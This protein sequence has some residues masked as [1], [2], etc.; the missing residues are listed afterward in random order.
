MNDYLPQ[1]RVEQIRLA[2]SQ[3]PILTVTNIVGSAILMS[4]MRGLVPDTVLYAWIIVVFLTVV[5]ATS[6]LL[7]FYQSDTLTEQNA[8]KWNRRIV[9]L[10]FFRA[11]AWGSSGF[12]FFVPNDHLQQLMIFS[13][14]LVGSFF[15]TMQ[16]AAHKPGFYAASVFIVLPVTARHFLEIGPFHTTL[17]WLG[18]L[19]LVTLIYFYRKIH[20][21]LQDSLLLRFEKSD[22]AQK[23]EAQKT[24]LEYQKQQAEQANLAKSQFLA[25]ASHDLRQPLHAQGLFVGELQERVRDR[26]CQQ[27]LA[28]LK[29]SM[30]AMHGLFNSLLDISR[31]EAQV[32]EP[33][34][35][36]FSIK[37]LLRELHLDF[38][39][40][41]RD[42][43][44]ILRVVDS[45]AVIRSDP[46]LLQRILRNL[47]SNAVRYTF[48]GKIL[49]GCR[50]R[51]EYLQIQ[52]WDTGIGIPV[53]D[54]KLIFQEFRQLHNPER[55][56]QKGL[57]LGLAIV[58]RLAKLL[59]YTVE[60]TS[61]VNKGSV[62]SVTVPYVN[63][64]KAR[65]AAPSMTIDK[66]SGLDG[67]VIVV[68]DDEQDILI[69]MRR[70][71]TQWGC[72]VLTAESAAE[73]IAQIHA[74]AT[75]PTAIIADYRLHD[76]ETGI[77]AIKTIT[78]RFNKKIPGV[79]ITGDTAPDRLQEAHASGYQILHK[80][81]PPAKLRALLSNMVQLQKM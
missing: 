64:C 25:A 27:I 67:C 20:G 14:I 46:T 81:L 45:N 50:R 33:K 6:V 7:F 39:G 59:E 44:L 68:I 70:L 79:L 72:Q 29:T 61:T 18:V 24:E 5:V 13:F 41:A 52:V 10:G 15:V 30:E 32:V 26:E 3:L 78:A 31:L 21:T 49:I 37:I 47:V 16:M 57:G 74:T 17:S 4:L 8:A 12:L 51:G 22:L 40:R 66:N 28:N 42:K 73:A 62:F 71:L 48:Q 53:A 63:T 55:N 23:L 11:A 69:S 75:Q 43:G 35:E 1:V 34:L 38:A 76:H 58:D 80:P 65:I 2:Y 19:Y 54:Q 77:E 9:T 36:D 56:R 60:V